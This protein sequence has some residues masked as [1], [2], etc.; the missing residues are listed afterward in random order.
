M[1]SAIVY[2]IA[3]IIL[4]VLLFFIIKV[5]MR[6]AVRLAMFVLM[7]I[8]L[9]TSVLWQSCHRAPRTPQNRARSTPARR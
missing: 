2:V 1:D 3:G 7:I 6:W 4:L 5:A 8:V 9:T